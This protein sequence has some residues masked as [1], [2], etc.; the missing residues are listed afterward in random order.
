MYVHSRVCDVGDCAACVPSPTQLAKAQTSAVAAAIAA[1]VDP[2]PASVKAM[3]EAMQAVEQYKRQRP[4]FQRS[5]TIGDLEANN[6]VG[7]YT[8]VFLRSASCV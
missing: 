7:M 1:G 3:K 8:F 5:V 4:K 6:D 2:L